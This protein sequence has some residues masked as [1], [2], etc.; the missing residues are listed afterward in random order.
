MLEAPRLSKIG[1]RWRGRF[2]VGRLDEADDSRRG[3]A[4]GALQRI[5]LQDTLDQGGPPARLEAQDRRFP[6]ELEDQR[7]WIDDYAV[8][9][10]VA[11]DLQL[12]RLARFRGD[13]DA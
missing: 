2:S 7:V 5:D 8:G 13:R 10:E 9:L 6:V 12:G 4:R 11:G 3:P 1:I